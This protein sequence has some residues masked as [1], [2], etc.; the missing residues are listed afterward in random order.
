MNLELVKEALESS[1]SLL[2]EELEGV[3]LD[4]LREEYLLV[5]KKIEK[6]LIILETNG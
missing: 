2:S 6:A 5:M 4:E 1:L 3:E